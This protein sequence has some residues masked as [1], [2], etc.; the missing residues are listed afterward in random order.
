MD[1]ALLFPP[2]WYFA[3]VPADL[4]H[5]AGSLVARGH[6][7]YA[8][9][10]SAALLHHHLGK[11]PAFQ[12]Y[13]SERT[14]PNPVAHAAAEDALYQQTRALGVR[15]GCDWGPRHLRFP[16]I[17]EAHVP[18]ALERGR[19]PFR[20]PALPL[21]QQAAR[22]VLALE[23]TV[24][25]IALV[26]PDQRVQALTLAS[27]LRPH[28]RRIVLYGCLEDVLAPTDFAPSLLGQH[29]LFDLFDGVV[30]GDADDAL[31]A[32]C[33]PTVAV[34]D[35]PNTLVSGASALPPRVRQALDAVP[36]FS[37]VRAEHHLAPTPVIDL[38]LGRGCPWGRCRFCGIQA[39][40]P[41]YRAGTVD[42]V[43][44]GMRAAHEALGSTVFR[45]RDDLLTPRQLAELAAHTAS[46]PFRPRWMARARFTSGLTE[47]V[48]RSAHAGGLEELWLGLESAVPR[49]RDAM[50]KG[51]PQGVVLRVLEATARVGIRVRLLCMVG[52][53]GETEA[54]ARQTVE[55][56]RSHPTAAF[57][58][59]PFMEV[60]AAPLSQAEAPRDPS[61]ID[62]V[63]PRATPDWLR[64]VLD[65]AVA[66]GVSRTTPG[67]DPVHRWLSALPPG[68][69]QP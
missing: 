22:E 11:H 12:A 1:A 20:N 18:R 28:H 31:L 54:E 3:A 21:L 16:D 6:T 34:R 60:R 26:H 64:P 2:Q 68:R 10:G 37:H 67:P 69:L 44:Q 30:L 33:D 15:F 63:V 65:E 35:A 50:D 17:D 52:Y 19:D 43:V 7:V 58:V 40:H 49:V 51:V 14:F 57:S 29:A 66:L 8:W 24:I 38:R 9:D 39:H 62:H 27:L 13:Q 41:G 4:S 56:L 36:D 42:R 47:S 45:V 61:R 55:F 23:P 59:T 46:L 48:L 53:P 32:L 5:S 25:A